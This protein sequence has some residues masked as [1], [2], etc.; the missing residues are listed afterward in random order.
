MTPTTDAKSVEMRAVEWLIAR[1]EHQTWTDENQKELDAWLADLPAHLTA[2]W[3]VEASWSRTDLIADLR[4]FGLGVNRVPPGGRSW[5][6][7]F[8][9]AAGL[10]LFAV[11]GVSGTLYFERP[12]LQTFATPIGGHKVITLFDG[13]QIELNTNTVLR[14]GM[15]ENQRSVTLVKGEAY[16]QI[17]HDAAHAFTVVAAGHRVTDLG[18]KFL[19]RASG[20][21][22]EVAL[23]EGRA[24]FELDSGNQGRPL[25]LVPGDVAL[26]MAHAVTIEKKPTQ[27]LLVD[28]AWRKGILVFDDTPLADAAAEFNR[29]NAEKIVIEG[30]GG[31]RLNINGAIRVNDRDEFARLAKNLFGLRVEKHGNETVIL[32]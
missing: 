2:F 7:L 17:H 16:F 25:T 8:R 29:Y 11:L 6:T 13:S 27:R 24:R 14:I 26:A 3:R 10:G 19:M 31:A 18:T 4:P 12:Q 1:D 15:G 22:L 32:R 28:L 21:K 23:L 20:E 9:V 5:L 30:L